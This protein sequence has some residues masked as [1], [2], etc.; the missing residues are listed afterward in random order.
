MIEPVA[1]L[2][3][4]HVYGMCFCLLLL[5]L[6]LGMFPVDSLHQYK[7]SVPHDSVEAR[8]ESAPFLTG[9]ALPVMLPAATSAGT[10]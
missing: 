8:V 3:V 1:H 4:Q 10:A 5:A 6:K 7:Q 9:D 2:Y